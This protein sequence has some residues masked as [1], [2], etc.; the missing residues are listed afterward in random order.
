MLTPR[1]LLLMIAS[2]VVCFGAYQIY[3]YFLGHYDG[4]P[5]L[6]PEYRFNP[7]VTYETGELSEER[8]QKQRH[9]I[10]KL[11]E[12]AF[13]P[14]CPELNRARTLEIGKPESRTVMAFDDW[15]LTNGKLRLVKVS[16]ANFKRLPADGKQEEREEI[17]TMQGDV[18]VILFNQPIKTFIEFTQKVKPVSGHIESDEIKITHN[19]GTASRVDDVIIYCKKRIDF[20]DEQKRIWADDKV[21]VLYADPVEARFEGVGLEITLASELVN[22]TEEKAKPK[23]K[24]DQA[25]PALGMSAVKKITLEH[26]VEFTFFK[27]NGSFLAGAVAKSEDK[28]KPEATAIP[29]QPMIIRCKDQ[30]S[31]DVPAHLAVFN[32]RVNAYRHRTVVEGAKTR[33]LFDELDADERLTLE[34]MPPARKPKSTKKPSDESVEQ[35]EL[36]KAVATGKLVKITANDDRQG[37][38]L[39]A[40]GIELVYD[41][42]AQEARLRGKDQ[43]VARLAEYDI[44]A[45]GM[46]KILLPANDAADKDPRG[47]II[48]GPGE[49]KLR[50][51]A[52]N[53]DPYTLA[54]WQ[55]ELQ[56]H[57]TLEEHRIELAGSA[58]LMHEKQGQMSGETVKA[59]LLPGDG[60]KKDKKP[61]LDT[62]SLEKFDGR[63]KRVEVDQRVNVMSSRLMVQG[64]NKLTLNFT[65]APEG[66][67]LNKPN[68]A[69]FLQPPVA[70]KA[71]VPS[72]KTAVRPPTAPVTPTPPLYLQAAEIDGDI[73]M[74][75]DKQQVLRRLEARENVH[76][77]RKTEPGKQNGFDI[78]GQRLEMSLQGNTDLYRVKLF[79]NKATLSMEKFGLEGQQ[80]DLDQAENRVTIPGPGKF[81][82]YTEQDFQGRKLLKPELVTFLWDEKMEFGGRAAQFIGNVVTE[83][84]DPTKG[85]I[86]LS[87]YS[88]TITLDRAM[89]LAGKDEQ[90][91]LS[92]QL[93]SPPQ[94]QAVNIES[95][96]CISNPQSSGGRVNPVVVEQRYSPNTPQRQI[97]RI[98]GVQVVF[99]NSR[100]DHE[101]LKVYGPGEVNLVRAGKDQLGDISGLQ[102]SPNVAPQAT[103]TP[104]S[105]AMKLTRVTFEQEMEYKKN[106]GT[107]RF[108]KS[109]K[110]FY[111]P[112]EDL[113][114]PLDERRLP[115]DGIY[116]ACEKMEIAT[117]V[118]KKTGTNFHEMKASGNTEMR[119][120]QT[121]Y[122]KADE[123]NFSEEKGIATM[124]GLNGNDALHYVQERPGSPYTIQRAKSFRYFLK[125]G[126][127]H[128]DSVKSIQVK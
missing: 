83:N 98:E 4:L 82:F 122:V 27:L 32:T 44:F 52:R 41:N 34:L 91:Q 85:N 78:R 107:L 31:Y 58:V 45:R 5:P 101:I 15:N 23:T 24:P 105:V 68:D 63:L 39:Y 110:T 26:D 8:Y 84:G 2:F 35:F 77:E 106:E 95:V 54:S 21:Q 61:G 50:A 113:S 73:L 90:P 125:T 119:G 89:S 116:M 9:E 13:G 128:G 87:C 62:A 47:L 49:I 18:A 114:V 17:V 14:K 109:V 108:W 33:E 19:H 64:A 7:N 36:K 88:M 120:N 59:W 104:E 71:D 40:E 99:D 112:G 80:I 123:L 46:V 66:F 126:E 100:K 10:A 75:G 56:W 86:T 51:S 37:S 6:P 42:V 22:R 3:A 111:V 25:E 1:R 79:G 94:Q 97:I 127:F 65:D 93:Q 81:R 115:K 57:R 74:I 38:G 121:S 20:N 48:N 67:V 43:V 76:I 96:I 60:K 72:D 103:A 70:A 92:A 53:P 55:K 102:R 124:S 28:P 69:P 117:T 30:F 118:D 29:P 12:R 11:L 16:I